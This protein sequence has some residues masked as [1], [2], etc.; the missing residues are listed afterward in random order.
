MKQ[1]LKSLIGFTLTATDGDIGKIKDFYFDDE[2]WSVRY[3]IVDTGN[4]LT[5]R[6]ILLSPEALYLPDRK[7][8]TVSTNL[9]LDQ[10]E[11]SPNV[12]TEKPVSRQQ[13]INLYTYYSW[14][15]YWASSGVVRYN[16]MGLPVIEDELNKKDEN[17]HLRSTNQVIDYNVKANDGDIGDVEDFIVEETNWKIE[18]IIIDTGKWFTGKKVLL[19][20]DKIKAINWNTGNLVID[21][22]IKKVKNSPIYDPENEFTEVYALIH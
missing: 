21:S 11:K 17:K 9:S 3:I 6:V 8:N 2:S 18:F 1:N 15:A 5:G 13:E 20:P 14:N 22:T 4:W 10:I 19:S 16:H 7:K 12:N